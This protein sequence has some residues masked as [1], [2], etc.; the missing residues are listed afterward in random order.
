MPPIAD[1]IRS[2]NASIPVVLRHNLEPDAFEPVK[3]WDWL[4]AEAAKTLENQRAPRCLS[5]FFHS[6][7]EATKMLDR[8]IDDKKIRPT[9]HLSANNLSANSP[10]IP[11]HRAAIRRSEFSLPLKCV[12]RDSLLDQADRRFEDGCGHG[13][14]VQWLTWLGSPAKAGTSA[15]SDRHPVNP[16][17]LLVCSRRHVASFFDLTEQERAAVFRLVTELKSHDARSRTF[18]SEV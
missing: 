12:L 10:P 18:D 11:R 1:P 4:R 16:G 5:P 15:A 7:G 14:D 13:V 17:Y 3:K 9:F 6:L 2:P 8:N